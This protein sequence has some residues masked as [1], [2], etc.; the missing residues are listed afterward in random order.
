M[1]K[2]SGFEASA[3]SSDP[4]M[5]PEGEDMCMIDPVLERLFLNSVMAVHSGNRMDSKGF[6]EFI[7][8]DERTV[9]FHSQNLCHLHKSYL[10]LEP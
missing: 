6:A 5:E 9:Q 2:I 8:R 7:D 1:I 10:F 4:S 3:V